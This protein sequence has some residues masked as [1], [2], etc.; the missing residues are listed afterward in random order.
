MAI[1]IT[2]LVKPSP[3]ALA[4]NPTNTANLFDLN[5]FSSQTRMK[6][7]KIKAGTQGMTAT[8]GIETKADRK[9]APY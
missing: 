4:V 9:F 3:L 2:Q 6:P 5:N 8:P 7:L 1:P